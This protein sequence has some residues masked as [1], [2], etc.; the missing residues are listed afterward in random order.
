CRCRPPW[1]GS[2][3]DGTTIF[4]T[5]K[6]EARRLRLCIR[7]KAASGGRRHPPREL[8]MRRLGLCGALLLTAVFASPAHGQVGL[9]WKWTK[10]GEF[11]V[12]TET[13]VK[14]TFV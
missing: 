10:D 8:P 3:I 13:K 2:I 14:Q 5:T 6:P 11:Y 12:R 9:A 1:N 4:S 7:C